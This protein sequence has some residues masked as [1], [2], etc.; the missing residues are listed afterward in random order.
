MLR[1]FYCRPWHGIFLVMPAFTLAYGLMCRLLAGRGWFPAARRLA[2]G[3]ALVLWLLFLVQHTLLNRASAG[4]QAMHPLFESY[5]MAAVQREIYRS[6]MMNILLFFPGGLCL[7]ALLPEKWRVAGLC[8]TVLAL[9]LLSFG[10]EYIQYTHA[11]GVA[12]MDDVLHNTL[13]AVFGAGAA[14]MGTI[15]Q[16]KR[17]QSWERSSF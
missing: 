3:G 6:N 1:W 4:V 5:R 14:A 17:G 12:E 2:C 11:L 10:I 16:T 15:I 7:R 9:G 13:G 8:L